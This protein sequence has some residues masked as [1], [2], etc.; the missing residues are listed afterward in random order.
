MLGD[1]DGC[2]EA[3]AVEGCDQCGYNICINCGGFDE[4]GWFCLQKVRSRTGCKKYEE[5]KK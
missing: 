5:E 3:G 2:G 1:C 4:E